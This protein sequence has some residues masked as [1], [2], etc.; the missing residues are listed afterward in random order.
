[1]LW[2][3]VHKHRHVMVYMC[4]E[5]VVAYLSWLVM[6]RKVSRILEAMMVYACFDA[7]SGWSIRRYARNMMWWDWS[8]VWL[9]FDAVTADGTSVAAVRHAD[10]EWGASL[11]VWSGPWKWSRTHT[12][13]LACRLV[14]LD[15][16]L[17]SACWAPPVKS[18]NVQPPCILNGR[19]PILSLVIFALSLVSRT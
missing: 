14:L 4:H 9:S 8:S 7:Y 5:Q 13:M 18:M 12:N 10:E 1:M 19:V 17:W 15:C 3:H 2:V 16:D 11:Q 6:N